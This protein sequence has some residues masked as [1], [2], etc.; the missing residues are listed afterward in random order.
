M[1]ENLFDLTGELTVIT[2]GTG[3]IGKAFAVA[4]LNAGARVCV[5]GRGKTVAIDKVLSE[6]TAEAGARDR[7]FGVEADTSSKTQVEEALA[8]VVRE[9]GKP[10]VLINGVGGNKSKTSFIDTD[11]DTFREILDLN[12][13]AG[14]VIP[15]QVF[16]EFWIREK[17]EGA[18]INIAS[19]TSYKPLSGV[20]AY[21]AAKAGVLNLTMASAKEFAPHGIRVNGIAPGFFVGHQNKNLL[22]DDYE[23]GKLSARGKSIIERTPYGRFGEAADLHGAVVFLASRKASGFIT[24]VTLPVD[25][26]FLIDGI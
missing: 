9:F 2:G 23:T 19:M 7:I 16:A 21:D 11:I 22:Y 14:L 18:I 20:W 4:L 12:L 1:K 15:T 26:G 24:G 5:W 8:R 3:A 13:V 17:T 25:G 6:I 10:T